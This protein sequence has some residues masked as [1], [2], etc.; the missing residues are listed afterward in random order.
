M[1]KNDEHKIWIINELNYKISFENIYKMHMG[2]FVFS[3]HQAKNNPKIWALLAQ[4]EV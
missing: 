3:F 1:K 2:C 4:N